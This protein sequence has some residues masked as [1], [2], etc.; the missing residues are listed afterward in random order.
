MVPVVCLIGDNM[1]HAV[2]APKPEW[3]PASVLSSQG[4]DG[5]PLVLGHPA[6]DGRQVSANDPRIMEQHAFG[7][8]AATHLKGKRLG[9]EA[10][11]DV[12]RLEAMGQQKMLEKARKGEPIEVSVGAFVQT[13]DA[14]GRTEWATMA[15]D[16]LAF[17]PDGVGACSVE[18]GCGANR[19]AMRVC[20]DT[21]ELEALRDI[22]QSERDKMDDSDFAGPGTSF[23]I[24]TQADLDAASHLIGKAA[25]PDAVKAKA[26]KIA[27]RK[28]LT[29]PKAWQLKGAQMKLSAKIKALLAPVM[30]TLDDTPEEGEENDDPDEKSEDISY[31]SIKELITQA[32]ASLAAGEVHVD[33]LIAENGAGDDEG[34]EDSRL[35]AVVAMCVQGYG[36]LNG[37]IKLATSCLAPD[38]S[39][40]PMAYMEARAAAGARHNAG[41]QK[42]INDTHDNMVKLGADCPSMK[43]AAGACG[44]GGSMS[45]AEMIQ[46]IL[47]AGKKDELTADQLKALEEYVP[48]ATIATLHVLAAKSPQDVMIQTKA[49]A[50]AALAAHA[51]GLNMQDQADAAKAKAKA[52][53]DAKDKKAGKSKDDKDPDED[54]DDDSSDVKAAKAHRR[55]LK[56][57]EAAGLS[58]EDYEE[59]EWLK[60]APKR[61][62][63]MAANDKAAK[64][65]RK[66]ELV[67]ALKG[68]PLTDKQLE[69]KPVEELETLAAYAGIKP[70]DETDYSGRGLPELTA[71]QGDVYRNPPNG[72]DEAIKRAKAAH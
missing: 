59:Q 21:L 45:K 38:G 68:G 32:K 29:L 34:V 14:D 10:W 31:A 36:T 51:H 67:A 69:A 71:A 25:N 3:V 33:A 1:I 56:A 27:K 13:R 55:T 22:P 40:S 35:E 72:Y 70:K 62:R 60:T 17:L 65:A 19:A 11:M 66:T 49:N 30:K 4:W 39:T 15:P 6:K 48:D 7:F 23:P 46:K 53:Q 50:D 5:R 44:C 18:M 64:A 61:F 42:I 2:N 47:A 54:D 37:I 24:K 41:D 16:H 52:D 58:V 57:A 8:M 26:I 43:A 9:T 28:G 12:A 20:G 63:D